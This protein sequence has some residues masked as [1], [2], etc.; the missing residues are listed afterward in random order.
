MLS[1]FA[2]HIP[3]GKKSELVEKYRKRARERKHSLPYPVYASLVEE[4]IDQIGRIVKEVEAQGVSDYTMIVFTSDNGGLIRRYDYN[5]ES[6]NIV[7]DLAPLKGEKGSLNE[8]G[9][10]VP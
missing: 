4:V 5:E 8:G 7:S 10:R 3:M 6:E 1:L 2:V 9:I